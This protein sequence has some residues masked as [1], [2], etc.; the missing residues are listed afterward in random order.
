MNCLAPD[1]SLETTNL[2]TQGL[3]DSRHVSLPQW[4][5]PLVLTALVFNLYV[6][7]GLYSGWLS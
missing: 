2:F 3:G 1:P 6:P 5:L 4:E 7:L